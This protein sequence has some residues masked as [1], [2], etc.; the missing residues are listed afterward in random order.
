LSLGT[1]GISVV[2][3]ATKKV[4]KTWPRKGFFQQMTW[5]PDGGEVW[6]TVGQAWTVDASFPLA[7]ARL[8]TDA[9]AYRGSA[10]IR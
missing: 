4:D 10:L 6:F 9:S 3:V 8:T 5:S 2:D 7:V 1:K